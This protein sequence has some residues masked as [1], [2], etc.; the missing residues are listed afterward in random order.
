[1][2]TQKQRRSYRT[3]HHQQEGEE[4]TSIFAQIWKGQR[5]YWSSEQEEE[6]EDVYGETN[7]GKKDPLRS[8][9]LRSYTMV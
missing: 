2:D 4:N 5:P 7:C 1:M 3:S 9:T 8:E 6:G